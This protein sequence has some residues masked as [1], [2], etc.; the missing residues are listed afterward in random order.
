MNNKQI[1]KLAL[2]FLPTPLTAKYTMTSSDML[3]LRLHVNEEHYFSNSWVW[4]RLSFYIRSCT[5]C[6]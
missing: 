2:S 1:Y 4:I 3:A 5:A 6:V